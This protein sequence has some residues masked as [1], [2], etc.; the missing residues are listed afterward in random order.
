LLQGVTTHLI[1]EKIDRGLLV[2][3]ETIQIYKDDTI[4]DLQIR[5]QN[6]EQKKMISSIALLANIQIEQLSPLQK[7]AYHNAMPPDVEKHLIQY[8]EQYTKKWSNK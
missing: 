3:S 7:G 2:E 4:M 1:D 8:M 6:L 5:V